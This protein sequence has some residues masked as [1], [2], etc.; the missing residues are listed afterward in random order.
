MTPKII[1]FFFHFVIKLPN[2]KASVTYPNEFQIDM[3]SVRLK[4]KTRLKKMMYVTVQL[5][6]NSLIYFLLVSQLDYISVILCILQFK[7][8]LNLKS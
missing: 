2:N 5:I 6:S 1:I 3:M 7:F 4:L 8:Y